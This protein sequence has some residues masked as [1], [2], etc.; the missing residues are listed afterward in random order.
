[1]KLQLSKNFVA[2]V[3]YSKQ[4]RKFISKFIT[5]FGKKSHCWGK[6]VEI[7]LNRDF[8]FLESRGVGTVLFLYFFRKCKERGFIVFFSCNVSYL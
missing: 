7:L 5:V 6:I 1:M 4:K 3:R 8:V 2:N